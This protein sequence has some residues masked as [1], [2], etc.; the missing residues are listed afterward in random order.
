MTDHANNTKLIEIT[1]LLGMEAN[2]R[3]G[4]YTLRHNGQYIGQMSADA[5]LDHFRN[6][7]AKSGRC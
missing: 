7:A 4:M 5:W 1:R 6:C 3:S 2:Y